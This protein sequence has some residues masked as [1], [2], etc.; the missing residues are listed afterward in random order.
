MP[1]SAISAMRWRFAFAA[2][3][4]PSLTRSSF[5]FFCWS[6]AAVTP[7]CSPSISRV[8]CSAGARPSDRSAAERVLRLALVERGL[9]EIV[10]EALR[11][12]VVAGSFARGLREIVEE[13]LRR[14]VVAGLVL[15]LDR[16]AGEI[17]EEALRRDVLAD[18]P[19][20]AAA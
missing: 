12:D 10:E 2:L 15:R 6:L 9:R 8:P 19:T 16:L 1:S 11:R 3:S 17:L 20:A 13:A 5:G 18:G 14:D 7:F 4:A